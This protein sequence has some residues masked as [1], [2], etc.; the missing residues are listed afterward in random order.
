MESAAERLSTIGYQ[1]KSISE[2]VGELVASDV[3]ILV[4]IR[5]KAISRKPGFSKTRLRNEL[6]AAGIEYQHFPD[7]G[8]PTHLLPKRNL[9]DNGEILLA[10][11][12]QLYQHIDTIQ[13]LIEQA[14]DKNVCLLCFEAD[15]QICHRGVLANRLV[16][17][18]GFEVDHL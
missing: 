11:E 7:L 17:D 12:Q 15:H 9:K 5:R 8:M 13:Q 4:D 10:Y 2:F 1:G 3:Q 14:T 6:E 18:A 16:E